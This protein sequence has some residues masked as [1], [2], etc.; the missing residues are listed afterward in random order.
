MFFKSKNTNVKHVPYDVYELICEKVDNYKDLHYLGLVNKDLNHLVKNRF[1]KI[2]DKPNYEEKVMEQFK[3]C[4]IDLGIEDLRGRHENFCDII[5]FANI[6]ATFLRE[7]KC[8]YYLNCRR[9]TFYELATFHTKR[10][11]NKCEIICTVATRNGNVVYVL[12]IDGGTYTDIMESLTCNN[13]IY[14]LLHILNCI[15]SSAGYNVHGLTRLIDATIFKFEKQLPRTFYNLATY[16]SNDIVGIKF[17]LI[18]Q[19]DMDIGYE[20]VKNFIRRCDLPILEHLPLPLLLPLLPLDEH[21]ILDEFDNVDES[22]RFETIRKINNVNSLILDGKTMK[23]ILQVEDNIKIATGHHVE[24]FN[25][26][27]TIDSYILKSDVNNMFGNEKLALTRAREAFVQKVVNS[28]NEKVFDLNNVLNIIGERFLS[29]PG[30][31]L[32]CNETTN[33]YKVIHKH[34]YYF[35]I[36][37][38]F[39]KINLDYFKMFNIVLSTMM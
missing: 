8:K 26:I 28:N 22:F 7:K 13:S 14:H 18:K 20:M 25:F 23:N 10:E 33:V 34:E 15:S 27:K 17:D 1:K 36:G 6:L 30:F 32:E 24:I 12:N 35:C 31:I 39:Y 21:D 3:A 2:F 38:D 16:T 4:A 9:H 5:N 29:P 37:G 19:I 11:K